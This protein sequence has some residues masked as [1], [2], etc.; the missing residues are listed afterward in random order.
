MDATCGAAGPARPR[1]PSC[2]S[3]PR[4]RQFNGEVVDAGSCGDGGRVGGEV[5]GSFA[6]ASVLLLPKSGNRETGGVFDFG[7]GV[8]SVAERLSVTGEDRTAC[9]LRSSNSSFV[10]GCSA[11]TLPMHSWPFCRGQRFIEWISQKG[12]P[13]SIHHWCR[14]R[15]A[16][17]KETFVPP[18]RG[19]RQGGR[20]GEVL[21]NT[22]RGNGC[23]NASLTFVFTEAE[24]TCVRRSS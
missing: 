18:K 12:K 22:R 19:W 8:K 1:E 23:A 21:R 2:L 20:K 7:S 10:D 14:S 13:Q 15:S 17:A 24:V 5:I 16:I 4:R 9:C 11:R 6:T 3:R